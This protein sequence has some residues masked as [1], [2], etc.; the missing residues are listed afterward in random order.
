MRGGELLS[1]PLVEG[2]N[3]TSMKKMCPLSCSLAP[4]R[5]TGQLSRS[6]L[7]I[8]QVSLEDAVSADVTHS[9]VG[10][11]WTPGLMSLYS[12]TPSLSLSLSLSLSP[13]CSNNVTPVRNLSFLF[14][15]PFEATVWERAA[16]SLL[17]Q[18]RAADYLN[19]ETKVWRV[20]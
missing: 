13:R 18:S 6:K 12:H 9:S 19:S 17:R 2:T 8:E 7:S 15:R 20:V 11:H 14:G 1:P 5:R 4:S 10:P 16:D 3:P